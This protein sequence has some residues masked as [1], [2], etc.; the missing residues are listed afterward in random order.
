M[1]RKARRARKKEEELLHLPLLEA[2]LV[3]LL[4]AVEVAMRVFKVVV[5]VVVRKLPKQV[6]VV[7]MKETGRMEEEQ[8]RERRDRPDQSLSPTPTSAAAASRAGC[9]TS[10]RIITSCLVSCNYL[11]TLITLYH[12]V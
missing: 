1:L 7:V 2:M 8:E 5:A 9:A 3:L 4:G 12:R 10:F 11:S 6:T